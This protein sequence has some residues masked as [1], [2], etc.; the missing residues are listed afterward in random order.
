MEETKQ[1]RTIKKSTERG[2][3]FQEKEAKGEGKGKDLL[4]RTVS[5]GDMDSEE[6]N[7]EEASH[8]GGGVSDNKKDDDDYDSKSETRSLD[9]GELAEEG[10][11][12]MSDTRCVVT[13]M[14]MKQ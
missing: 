11:D 1:P 4:E 5:W 6:E 10:E 13:S 2:D 14:L 9:W 7:E 12:E 3:H 8:D